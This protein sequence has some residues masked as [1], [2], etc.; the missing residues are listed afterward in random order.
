MI[1]V[2]Q[3]KAARAMLGWSATELADRSGVG[4]ATVRRY[5]LQEGIPQA[6]TKILLALKTTMED[7]GIEFCGDPLLNP[8]VSLNKSK[9]KN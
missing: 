4:Q 8:G 7:S 9:Q 3:I 6:T 5:E 1:S 2:E